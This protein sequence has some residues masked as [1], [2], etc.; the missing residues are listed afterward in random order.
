MVRFGMLCFVGLV[1]AALMSTPTEARGLR[2]GCGCG[3]VSRSVNVS[4]Q[5]IVQRSVVRQRV[6]QDVFVHQPVILQSFVQPQVFCQPQIFSTQSYGGCGGSF[7]AQSF[8]SVRSF[9]SGGCSTFF[10]R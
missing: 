10:A 7:S 6:V 9:S 8:G 4:R 1:M 5:R 2:S 3:G